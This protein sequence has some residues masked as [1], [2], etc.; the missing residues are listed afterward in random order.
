MVKEQ[1]I[2]INENDHY[3]KKPYRC[4]YFYD[5]G[6]I[7]YNVQKKNSNYKPWLKAEGENAK[8]FYYEVDK[9]KALPDDTPLVV[10]NKAFEGTRHYNHYRQQKL[11]R[12][13]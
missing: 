13:Y 12:T 8:Y 9:I 3:D 4:P 10:E 5:N 11:V 7:L 1:Y 2:M 6:I